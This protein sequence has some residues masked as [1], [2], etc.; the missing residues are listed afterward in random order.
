V[1]VETIIDG[2]RRYAAAKVNIDSR[3]LKM[4]ATWLR[5]KCWREDPQPPRR[6][7][8]KP[9]RAPKPD[10][11]SKPDPLEGEY[12]SERIAREAGFPAGTRVRDKECGRM[13]KVFGGETSNGKVRLDVAWD[14]RDLGSYLPSRL[15]AVPE[16]APKP[17]KANGNAEP[18]SPVQ[19]RARAA[20]LVVGVRVRQ[21][22]DGYDEECWKDEDELGK[23]IAV[24]RNGHVEVR[25]SDRRVDNRNYPE[26]CW[27]SLQVMSP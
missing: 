25:W 10:R 11:A 18:E 7:E 24:Y 14:S 27:D 17:A 3:W 15:E 6:K 26:E 22:N 20:G 8:P 19:V 16:S 13:G 5:D 2:A 23:V 4:P 1:S 21:V 12:E 9:E